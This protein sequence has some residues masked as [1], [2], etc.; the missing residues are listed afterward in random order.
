V[1][2]ERR[3][4]DAEELVNL[5]VGIKSSL[6]DDTLLVNASIFVSR[7]RDQQVRTSFQIDPGDPTSFVFVTDNAAKGSTIGFEADLRWIPGD[8]W[9]V[10]ANIGLLKTEFEDFQ[11][12]QVDLTGRAF[13]HAPEYT[14]AL[15]ASYDFANGFF[16]GVDLSARDAFYFDLS[17]DQESAPYELVNARI[18]YNA[19]AWSAALWVR[20]V[21]DE[22][23]AVRGFYFGNEPPD[24]PNALYTRSGDPR[25]FG[26]T[27]DKRF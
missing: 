14:L 13:A 23:Y 7:M 24:F 16:A 17:H 2:T 25:H 6:R 26:I 8:A 20:N 19:N 18:G 5:E 12:P 3:I 21:F 15:G 1:P 22:K 4:F 9:A 10:Y 11:T 27:F